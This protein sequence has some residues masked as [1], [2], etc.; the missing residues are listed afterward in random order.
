MSVSTVI[1]KNPHKVGID[2]FLE[3]TLYL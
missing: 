1:G 2:S 3:G